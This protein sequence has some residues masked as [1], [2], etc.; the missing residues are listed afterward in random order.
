MPR[1]GILLIAVALIMALGT[2]W[3]AKNWLQAER[4]AVQRSAQ[5][6]AKTVVGQR[7]LVAKAPIRTGQFLTPDLLKWIEWPAGGVDASY[8]VEGVRRMEDVVGAV[9]RNPIASGEPIGTGR[10]VLPGDRGFLA[11]VLQPGMRAVSVPVNVTS[12]ISGFVFPGDHVDLILTHVWSRDGEERRERRVGETILTSLRVLAI[13]QKL[14]AK[15]GE[16]TVARTITFEVTPKQSEIIA[17]ASE[18]GKMSLS[19]RSLALDDATDPDD[20]GVGSAGPDGRARNSYTLDSDASV[21]VRDGV[22]RNV[23][24]FRGAGATARK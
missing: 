8:I 5:P 24:V 3:L 9:A 21:L 14:D 19:L 15:P 16:T 2:G 17:V 22:R 10:I 11:A 6:T 12:G 4:V 18:M 13:D 23:L 1:R 20:R 7:V